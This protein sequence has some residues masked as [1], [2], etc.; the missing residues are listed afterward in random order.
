MTLVRGKKKVRATFDQYF[1]EELTDWL[2][3]EMKLN[4]REPLPASQLHFW[5]KPKNDDSGDHHDPRGCPSYVCKYID[6]MSSTEGKDIE[7]GASSCARIH[8]PHPNIIDAIHNR[9]TQVL[10]RS[11]RSPNPRSRSNNNVVENNLQH[12]SD[13]NSSDT[14]I[15]DKI[16]ELEIAAEYKIPENSEVLPGLAHTGPTEKVEKKKP[17]KGSNKFF[18]AI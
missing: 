17:K 8:K 3:A 5:D 13:S 10:P 11:P 7:Q 14:E 2:L 18:L 4:K 16:E 1:S 15:S 12:D 6:T 9:I